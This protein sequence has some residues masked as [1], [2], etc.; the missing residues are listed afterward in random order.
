MK[1][2]SAF[3][4]SVGGNYTF[5]SGCSG[6]TNSPGPSVP[7]GKSN[8]RAT[9]FGGRSQQSLLD[10]NDVGQ[11]SMNLMRVNG[12]IAP[13][14]A[15]LT[16]LTSSLDPASPASSVKAERSASAQHLSGSVSS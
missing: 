1:R 4:S 15:L 5:S 2:R 16:N 9:G 10:S 3:S 8:V 12:A 13:F 7:T 6:A 14:K 11:I